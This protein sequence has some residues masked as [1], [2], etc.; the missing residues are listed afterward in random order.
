MG[1]K[2]LAERLDLRERVADPTIVL[3]VPLQ[4]FHGQFGFRACKSMILGKKLVCE[5]STQEFLTVPSK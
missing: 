2:M 1:S 5:R 3:W 4:R